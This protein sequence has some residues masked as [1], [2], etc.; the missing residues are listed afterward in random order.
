MDLLV[1]DDASSTEGLRILCA[2]SVIA[3]DLVVID[4]RTGSRIC[5]FETEAVRVAI[6]RCQKE[7][8][9]AGPVYRAGTLVLRH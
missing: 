3:G 5:N 9:V 4:Y 8:V 7:I 2:R 6:Q 1:D